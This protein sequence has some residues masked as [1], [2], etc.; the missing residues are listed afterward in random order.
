MPTL[1]LGTSPLEA[2]VSTKS[3]RPRRDS[4]DHIVRLSVGF[5]PWVIGLSRILD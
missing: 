5:Y 1:M 3:A 2:R 4:P